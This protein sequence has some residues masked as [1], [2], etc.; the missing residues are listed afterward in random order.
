MAGG[1]H[2]SGAELKGLRI[3]KVEHHCSVGSKGPMD[4]QQVRQDTWECRVGDGAVH[5][6]FS[7][8][9]R[10]LQSSAVVT[11]L[12]RREADLDLSSAWLLWSPA[13]P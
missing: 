4:R 11:E 7:V 10:R 3:R 8:Q 5:T 1:H 12:Q 13:G 9:V 2:N 6:V